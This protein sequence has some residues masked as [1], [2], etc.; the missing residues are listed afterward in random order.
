MLADATLIRAGLIMTATGVV[1][2]ATVRYALDPATGDAIFGL[3]FLLYLAL[4]VVAVPRRQSE[5][6]A[7]GAFVA[8][9]AIYLT[10]ASTRNATHPIASAHFT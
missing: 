9:A 5:L 10:G 6:S 3:G 1:S 7:V 4:L 2:A 8:V